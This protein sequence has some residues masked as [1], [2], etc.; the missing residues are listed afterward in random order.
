ML[1]YNTVNRVI[2]EELEPQYLFS[3]DYWDL[4]LPAM[5][6]ASCCIFY[7]HVSTDL[8]FIYV[9]HL[10]KTKKFTNDLI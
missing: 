5:L 1:D 6:A 2:G 10:N 9:H 3:F 7:S 4:K 8:T